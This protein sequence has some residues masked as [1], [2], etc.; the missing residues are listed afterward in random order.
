MRQR[1]SA[2]Q[3]SNS[4]VKGHFRKKLD[5]LL[6]ETQTPDLIRAVWEIRNFQRGRSSSAG[7]F[8]SVPQDF[9]TAKLPSK[10]YL[11]EW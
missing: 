6:S 8:Y 2:A 3:L 4:I 11:Y 5:S 7:F 9:L 1:K 10:H